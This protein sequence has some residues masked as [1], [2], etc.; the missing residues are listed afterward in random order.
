MGFV[1]TEV[2]LGVIP[3][4]GKGRTQLHF[5]N[6]SSSDVQ[7]Y[8][9]SSAPGCA[10]VTNGP[11]LENRIVPVGQT[12]EID[13][14]LDVGAIGRTKSAWIC[15][16]LKDGRKFTAILKAT[17]KQEWYLTQ[18][19]VDFGDVAREAGESQERVVAFCSKAD[20]IVGELEA[21][22]SWLEATARP[23]Q[24]DEK[25]TQMIVLKVVPSKL[26]PGQNQTSVQFKTTNAIVS[27]G[28]ITVKARGVGR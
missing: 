15:V 28:G 12:I 20:T 13:V 6:R 3:W 17:I 11:L 26:R 18:E 27:K 24:G 21:G 9:V 19:M 23:P 25:G 5:E 16:S 1:E 10:L 8:G 14:E 4:G 2:D 7:L 22:I